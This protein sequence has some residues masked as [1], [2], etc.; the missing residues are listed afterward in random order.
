MH[1]VHPEGDYD[2][3]QTTILEPWS[4]KLNA[5]ISNANSAA[6]YFQSSNRLEYGVFAGPDRPPPTRQ[7]YSI[8]T[9]FYKAEDSN[10]FSADLFGSAFGSYQ[11]SDFAFTPVGGLDKDIQ[12]YD[13]S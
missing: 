8:P 2:Y 9:E 12:F 4:A 11:S 3:P 1:N 6:L 5:Q 10:V 7:N 13:N